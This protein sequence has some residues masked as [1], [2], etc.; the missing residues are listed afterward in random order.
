MD[1]KSN[2]MAIKIRKAVQFIWA[3]ILTAFQPEWRRMTVADASDTVPE[4][5]PDS[6]TAMQEPISMQEGPAVGITENPGT[7]A[8]ASDP[9]KNEQMIATAAEIARLKAE[10]NELKKELNTNSVISDALEK[11]KVDLANEKRAHEGRGRPRKNSVSR[12]LNLR[13]QWVILFNAGV[14]LGAISMNLTDF[15]NEAL[16]HLFKTEYP[17]LS[18]LLEQCNEPTD[19]NQL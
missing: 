7:P 12:H 5:T 14:E 13:I 17:G 9:A 1:M 16:E 2:K 10:I 6:G 3:W 18:A 4:S 19:Y 11:L 15:I 8:P